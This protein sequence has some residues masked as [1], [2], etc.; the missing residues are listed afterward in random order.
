MNS[1]GAKDESSR[2]KWPQNAQKITE[3]S[4]KGWR[5]MRIFIQDAPGEFYIA[6]KLSLLLTIAKQKTNAGIEI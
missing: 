1:S 5:M 6:V 4:E 3:Y 2:Y